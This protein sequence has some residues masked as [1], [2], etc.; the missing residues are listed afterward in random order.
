MKAKDIRQ[1]LRTTTDRAERYWVFVYLCNIVK[2][3][4]K[5]VVALTPWDYSDIFFMATD[6][7]LEEAYRDY[8][9]SFNK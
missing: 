4:G 7:Q 6:E 5:S 8:R 9:V 2:D 3:K 1:K